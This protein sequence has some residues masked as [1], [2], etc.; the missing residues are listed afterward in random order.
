MTFRLECFTSGRPPT[1]APPPASHRQ[2]RG[3]TEAAAAAPGDRVRPVFIRSG[4]ERVGLGGIHLPGAEGAGRAPGLARQLRAGIPAGHGGPRGGAGRCRRQQPGELGEAA[5]K[6][7]GPRRGVGA[8]ARRRA[9]G[10]PGRACPPRARAASRC[11]GH[12]APGLLPAPDRAH[13]LRLQGRNRTAG[14]GRKRNPRLQPGR[15]ADQ[16]GRVHPRISG[17]DRK[18]GADAD[19]RDPRPQRY[20]PGLPKTP[21]PGGRIPAVRSH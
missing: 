2:P 21:H 18:R 7:G 19:P 17:R 9:A 16:G 20:L 14:G 12:L 15:A 10:E 1:S 13:L 5:G 6:P 3:G 8:I 11:R 4:P